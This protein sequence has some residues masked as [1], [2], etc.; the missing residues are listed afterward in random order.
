MT[1]FD[2]YGYIKVSKEQTK[3]FVQEK[4]EGSD[5]KEMIDYCLKCTKKRCN[6]NCDEIK[7]LKRRTK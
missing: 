2:R 7:D 5:S 6:G 4:M 3:P 1:M